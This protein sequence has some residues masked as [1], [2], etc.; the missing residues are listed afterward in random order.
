MRT[1]CTSSRRKG[2]HVAGGA[3]SEYFF[4]SFGEV[5]R[6]GANHGI[7]DGVLSVPQGLG[8]GRA[9]GVELVE[10][11]AVLDEEPIAACMWSCSC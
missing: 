10:P 11:V 7:G 1:Q 5:D 8:T 3:V 2:P 6:R 4:C 9:V